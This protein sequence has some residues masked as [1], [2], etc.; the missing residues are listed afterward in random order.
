MEVIREEGENMRDNVYLICY[1]RLSTLCS[2]DLE[3]VELDDVLFSLYAE[4]GLP[5]LNLVELYKVNCTDYKSLKSLIGVV[6]EACTVCGPV[7]CDAIPLFVKISKNLSPKKL[8][9]GLAVYFAKG[10]ENYLELLKFIDSLGLNDEEF[11]VFARLLLQTDIQGCRSLAKLMKWFDPNDNMDSDFVSSCA[12]ILAFSPGA[13]SAAS[14]DADGARE[15]AGSARDFGAVSGAHSANAAVD[16]ELAR[17]RAEIFEIAKKYSKLWQR[18]L[19]DKKNMM[20]VRHALVEML[21]SGQVAE[22]AAFV[23]NPNFV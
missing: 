17:G 19:A 21:R 9:G 15:D 22:A 8:R 5:F 13:N 16:E 11:E 4:H 6:S 1:E 3:K 18:N 10:E 12:A 14:A 2:N 23:E 7:D 20:G